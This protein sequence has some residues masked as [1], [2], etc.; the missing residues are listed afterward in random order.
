MGGFG[1]YGSAVGGHQDRRHQAERTEPLGDRIGL[2]VAVMVLTGP[3]ETAFGLDGE[4][5]QVVDQPVFVVDALGGER[6]AELRLVDLLEDLLEPPVIDEKDSVLG[7][8]VER[9]AGLQGVGHSAAR[10]VGEQFVDIV[11][12]H[13]DAGTGEVG[14]LVFLGLASVLRIETDGHAARPRDLEIRGGGA[15]AEAMAGNDDGT[16]PAG[17][18]ARYVAADHRRPEQ[19][20][21]DDSANLRV[22]RFPGLLEAELLDARCIGVDGGTFHP[23]AVFP[24]R[25]GRLGGDAVVGRVAIGQREVET[26]EIDVEELQNQTVTNPAPDDPGHF[27]AVQFDNGVGDPNA[28]HPVTSP[29]PPGRRNATR[30]KRPAG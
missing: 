19:G 13:R 22:R 11:H 5:G 10:E 3:D 6:L 14:D 9:I 27:V 18:T 30:V 1:L 26:D 8:E 20:A 23:D 2:Y 15:V 4:A 21:A 7:A 24:D 28:V 16:G 29:K 12:G 25:L 17:N